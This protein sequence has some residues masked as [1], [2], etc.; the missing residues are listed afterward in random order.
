MFAGLPPSSSELAERKALLRH[1]LPQNGGANIG[2]SAYFVVVRR[3]KNGARCVPLLAP[4]AEAGAC[5]ASLAQRG[6]ARFT[7]AR[8]W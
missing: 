1:L 8:S 3:G 5:G 7:D 4:L 2:E 6:G